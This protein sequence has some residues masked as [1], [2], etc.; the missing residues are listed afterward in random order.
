MYEK[1]PT[2]LKQKTQWVNVWNGSKVPMQTGQKKA[3]S[4]VLPDTWGTFDCA[5]L[6][7]ANGIYDG[8]GYVFNDDGLIGIDIDDGFA[9]GLLNQLASDI[10]SHCQSYT[11]KSRSGRGVHI[12]LKGKLPFKGRNNRNGVEIYRSSR[13]F[14]MTGNVLLYSEI[15]E[16]QKAVDYVV[17]KYF[18]DAPKEGAGC[19]ASQRIYSPIYRKPEHSKIT[20]KPE[21]PPITTGS[22]NLSLTSLAGQLHNQG[23]SKAD[24]YKELLFANQQACK[25]P[26]PRSEIETIVNSVTRYRR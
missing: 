26:L 12:L 7:V 15:I 14:I 1:I 23:Y 6:N 10:I 9:D 2:E 13:Y 19:S 3:A 22:R 17:S 18:P 4:S 20:L 5:V 25:P 8:I 11:E 21:Y 24:I 16:N